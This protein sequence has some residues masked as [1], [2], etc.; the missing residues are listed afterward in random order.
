MERIRQLALNDEGFIFNP[1][2]GDSF[3][4][5]KT[6]LFIL[7]ALQQGKVFEELVPLLV[8]KYQISPEDSQED[9]GDFQRELER[10]NLITGRRKS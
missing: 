6:G 9:L 10:M 7:K 2:T 4:T 1:T 8:E 3:M 5:N